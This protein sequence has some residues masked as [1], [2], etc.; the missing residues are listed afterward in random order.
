MANWNKIGDLKL[1]E[2]GRPAVIGVD[3][4][5]NNPF[6]LCY[7]DTEAEAIAKAQANDNPEFDLI[8]VD[9]KAKQL[10]P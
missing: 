4:M 2:D 6:F 3:K 1:K 9:N 7:C 10:W 8:A 5:D